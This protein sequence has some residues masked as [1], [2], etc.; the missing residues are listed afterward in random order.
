VLHGCDSGEDIA[1]PQPQRKLVGVLKNRRVICSQ[2][3]R[4]SDRDR[5][6]IPRSTSVD[7]IVES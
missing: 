7:S 2:A 4:H 3:E 1:S 5:A 6:S